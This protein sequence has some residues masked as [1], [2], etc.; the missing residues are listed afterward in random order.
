MEIHVETQPK[1]TMVTAKSLENKPGIAAELFSHLGNAGFNIEMIT[2]SGVSDKFADISFA[3]AQDE[4]ERAIEHIKSLTHLDVKEFVSIKGMGIL[5]VF[6]R[7]FA[8]KPGLAGRVFS[9][10]A[11]EGVNIEMISTSLSSVSVLIRE[12]F[13][14]P[15]RNLLERELVQ[16]A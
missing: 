13:L 1:I 6:G 11:R 9:L 3:L 15:S 12:E 7:G 4:A 8:N 10:L 16:D 5:T 14:M 2:Q